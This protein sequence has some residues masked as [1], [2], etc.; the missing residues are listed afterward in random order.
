MTALCEQ[1]FSE[2]IQEIDGNEIDLLIEE[3]DTP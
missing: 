1:I 3:G 2:D